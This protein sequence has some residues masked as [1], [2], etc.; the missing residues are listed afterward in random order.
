MRTLL[1]M[2]CLVAWTGSARAGDDLDRAAISAGVNKVKSAVTACESKATSGGMVRVKVTV[3]AD[4][5]VT[6]AT[7]DATDKPLGDCVIGVLKGA[8]FAASKSGGSFSYPFLFATPADASAIP[9]STP[10]ANP[11]HG[12]PPE[13]MSP[14]A[15][16]LPEN[17]DRQ[18]ILDG[19]AR[20]RDKVRAC[21]KKAKSGGLVK[22]RTTVKPD[23]KVSA[24]TA[25]GVVDPTLAACAAGAMKRATFERTQTGGIFSFPFVLEPG[26]S[27]APA[28]DPLAS[29]KSIAFD[30]A[31]IAA[32]IAAVKSRITD[33]GV[34]FPTGGTVK[35]RVIVDP[36]GTV[37]RADLGA[38]QLQGPIQ[39]STDLEK[40]VV[41]TIK[42]A[43]FASTTS[44]GSF[45]YPFHF[46][47]AKKGTITPPSPPGAGQG[48]PATPP[49]PDDNLDRAKISEGV[50]KAKAAIT[51]CGSVAPD[52]KGAVK[53]KVVVL[54]SGAVSSAEITATPDKALGDC[55]AAA[56]KK[57]TFQATR[58]GGSFS[59]PFVF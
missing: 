51:A 27:N 17:L 57:A 50:A 54:P 7:T 19:V 26:V 56:L 3:G 52:A 40:C 47:P 44:G 31:L 21:S 55:V 33:C 42:T 10:P 37:S 43:T 29:S 18:M 30:R 9:P 58:D 23:G 25:D 48:T 45:S 59:Y 36:A 49:G 11:S 14:P 15:G 6:S 53:V 16:G 41:D 1:G 34:Q 4:G 39:P 32:G 46:G 38:N 20:I 35:V 8:T 22:I 13:P 24:A 2:L 5:K 12:K 28:K